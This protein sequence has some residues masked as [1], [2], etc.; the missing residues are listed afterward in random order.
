MLRDLLTDEIINIL[1][2]HKDKV[3]SLAFSPDGTVLASGSDDDTI[4]LWD[5]STGQEI[6]VLLGHV[7]DVNSVAFSP[8]GT[9]LVS[10]SND[11]TVRRWWM[12]GAL[13][14]RICQLLQRN[15]SEEEW[16][17]YLG[18]EPYRQTCPLE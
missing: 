11:G 12:A 18:D 4:L 10:G 9:S 14:Q 16:Q 13:A 3:S 1:T 5:V 6:G 2:G 7:D 15:L 17:R 8:D